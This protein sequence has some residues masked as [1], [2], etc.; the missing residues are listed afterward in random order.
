L[1]SELHHWAL[2]LIGK[3]L[4]DEAI[5]TF[6]ANLPTSPGSYVVGIEDPRN[7]SLQVLWNF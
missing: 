7:V 1:A 5:R 2:S 4:T 6:G 3:N